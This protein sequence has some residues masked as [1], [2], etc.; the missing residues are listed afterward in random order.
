MFDSL[1]RARPSCPLFNSIA[2]GTHVAKSPSVLM[3]WGSMVDIKCL[4]DA[5]LW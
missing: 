1:E 2:V 3:E 5:T 4:V